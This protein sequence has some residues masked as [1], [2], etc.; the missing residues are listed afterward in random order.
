MEKEIILVYAG[1]TLVKASKGQSKRGYR[2]IK[3]PNASNDSIER[4]KDAWHGFTTK[5]FEGKLTRWDSIGDC[6]SCIETDKGVKG[7]YKA[8]RELT[9]KIPASFILARGAEDKANL[10]E[11]TRLKEA[12]QRG[13]TK[14]HQK[15]LDDLRDAYRQT[16]PSMR[17]QFVAKLIYEITK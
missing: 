15:V 3:L 10:A 7:P 11:V 13:L 12:D 6:L 14:K 1:S 17:S 4:L 2:Y 9:Q 8:L 5:S 16:N